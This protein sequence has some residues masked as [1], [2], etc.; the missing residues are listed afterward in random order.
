MNRR[1][2]L[3]ANRRIKAYI[4]GY[5]TMAARGATWGNNEVRAKFLQLKLYRLIATLLNVREDC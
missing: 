5:C 1:R 4:Y 3:K 2:R